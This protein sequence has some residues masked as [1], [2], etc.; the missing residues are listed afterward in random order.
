MHFIIGSL[1]AA[2]L[3]WLGSATAAELPPQP[4]PGPGPAELSESTLR[5]TLQ[6]LVDQAT[7]LS[8]QLLRREAEH[9]AALADVRVSQSQR[10]PQLH[11]TGNSRARDL[12]GGDVP[13]GSSGSALNVN[14]VTPVFDWGRTRQAVSSQ[15]QLAHAARSQ[16]EISG[17]EIAAQVTRAWVELNRQHMIISVSQ[18]YL[19]RMQ[20]LVGLLDEIV[21]ADPGRGSELR[22]AQSRLLQARLA[23]TSAQT[24][25]REVQLVLG[26]LLG[27]DKV[28]PVQGHRWRL[29]RFNL[30]SMLA[31][32]PEHLQVRSTQA[33]ASGAEHQAN[34][35]RAGAR[36]RIDWT[37]G[38]STLE[39]TLG[40]QQPWHTRLSMTWTAF[41]GGAAR[42]A[43]RAARQRSEAAA[44]MAVQQK[45]DLAYQLRAADQTI[46]DSVARAHLYEQLSGESALIRE[47]FFEQWYHL[48]RRTL[49]DVLASESDHHGNRIGEVASLFDGYQA[50]FD[51]LFAAGAL[52]QWL[53]QESG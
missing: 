46:Q 44:Q 2:L 38:K 4:K 14:L 18:D 37:V 49:L 13:L 27:N 1:T 32:V 10:L 23:Q 48:G 16:V 51:G 41:D 50:H 12:G 53:G 47:A 29:G 28:T 34:S 42:S 26:R 6:T 17:E 31:R 40:Q 43:E 33:Q 9:Q 21:R 15:Q 22:Q 45:I 20:Y 39:D 7:D 24:K 35:I 8:P 25:A 3:L 19:D 36:P 11:L 5:R 30:E 52:R